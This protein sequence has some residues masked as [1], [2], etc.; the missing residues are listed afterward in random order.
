MS[1]KPEKY[2]LISGP[3]EFPT[4]INAYHVLSFTRRDDGG[5]EM[6]S[7]TGAKLTVPSDR[8]TVIEP[9]LN[10]HPPKVLDTSGI[11]ATICHPSFCLEQIAG[12][13]SNAGRE[14]AA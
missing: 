3:G 11:P 13:D 14:A 10:R 5:V 12:G 6:T 4:Y 1:R 2:V 9:Q 7:A 8:W